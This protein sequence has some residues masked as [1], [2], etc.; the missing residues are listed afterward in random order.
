LNDRM[1]ET[2]RHQ[3]EE[4]IDADLKE[5][6]MDALIARNDI[7]V[8]QS[9]VGKQM[10]YL[11]ERTR[12]RMARQRLSLEMMGLDEE[13]L[14]E[15]FEPEAI[16][17]VKGMILLDAVGRAEGITASEEEVDARITEV[18]AVGGAQQAEVAERYRQDRKLRDNLAM[19]LRDEK[20][21]TF[22]KEKATIREVEPKEQPASR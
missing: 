2:Y 20:V 15:R 12:E 19:Q 7:E 18:T 16:R 9:L 4:R 1:R 13:K 17:Q 22:L 5:R 14:K 3:E 8:P 21:M 11:V 10:E 6:L